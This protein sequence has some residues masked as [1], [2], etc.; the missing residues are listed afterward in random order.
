MAHDTDPRLDADHNLT[1][2]GGIL[3]LDSV[4]MNVSLHCEVTTAPKFREE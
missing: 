2:I 3:V 1:C 4:F